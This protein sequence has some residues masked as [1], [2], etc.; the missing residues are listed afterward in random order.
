MA[1]SRS[2]IELRQLGLPRAENLGD[3][4]HAALHLGL[5]LA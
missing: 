2:P 3:G 1:S 5:R 4:A